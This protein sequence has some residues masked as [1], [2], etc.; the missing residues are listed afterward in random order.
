MA[1]SDVYDALRSKRAYKEAFSH[2]KSLEIILSGKGLHFDPA[3][4]EI[5]LQAGD[6]FRTLY[7]TIR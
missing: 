1:I 6:E 3:L 7:D 4:T 2:E 5:F